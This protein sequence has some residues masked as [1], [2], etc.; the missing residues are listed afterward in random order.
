M[1]LFSQSKLT[2]KLKN[3]NSTL[4]TAPLKWVIKKFK[5]M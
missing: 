2:L 1:N 3:P 4:S 5:I